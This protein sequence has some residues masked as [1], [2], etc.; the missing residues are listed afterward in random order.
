MLLNDGRVKLT[1]GGS[2]IVHDAFRAILMVWSGD[3]SNTTEKEF[4]SVNTFATV[5]V[6][7]RF[8]SNDACTLTVCLFF[9]DTNPPANTTKSTMTIPMETASD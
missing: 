6:N 7:D 5:P 2:C 8:M 1:P 4:S 3:D 9:T